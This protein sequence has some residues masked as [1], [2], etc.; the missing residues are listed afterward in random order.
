M[1][2]AW[3]IVSSLLLVSLGF[4]AGR[5]AVP[6]LIEYVNIIQHVPQIET[7]YVYVY[8]NKP[9]VVKEVIVEKTIEIEKIVIQ[10]EIQQLRDFNSLQELK[11]F[12]A[13]DNT[14]TTLLRIDNKYS[15][16]RDC[17]K[18]VRALIA[19][20][21]KQGYDLHFMFVMPNT[22]IGNR[23]LTQAHAYALAIIGNN[24]YLVESFNDD[25]FLVAYLDQLNDPPIIRGIPSTAPVSPLVENDDEP[26]WGKGGNPDKEGWGKGGKPK[27]GE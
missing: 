8:V 26:D 23:Y 10:K 27:E 24:V 21:R 25:I 5:V 20:A 3:L 19:N 9:P 6:P 16:V 17:D 12:V 7:E 13:Q 18:Y 14:N 4:L 22:F 11:D 2:M 15:F 1:K